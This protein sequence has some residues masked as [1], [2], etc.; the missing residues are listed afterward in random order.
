MDRQPGL[1]LTD[2]GL[3]VC[4]ICLQGIPASEAGNCEAADYVIYYWGLECYD[5]WRRQKPAE[6]NPVSL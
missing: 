6:T 1:E 2:S 5:K 4:D 3:V